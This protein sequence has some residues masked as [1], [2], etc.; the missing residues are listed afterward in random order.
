MSRTETKTTQT[1]AS[2]RTSRM[3]PNRPRRLRRSEA[4]R[5]MVR[6]TILTPANLIHP[7]F[8]VPEKP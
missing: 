8:V 3:M 7:M 2:P 5:S 1:E 6:E 4:I